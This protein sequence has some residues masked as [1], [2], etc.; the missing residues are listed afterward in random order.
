MSLLSL[1]PVVSDIIG[2]IITNK[3]EK[4]AALAQLALLESTGELQ[5][6]LAQI[7]L[8]KEEAKS[9]NWFVAGW[10]PCVGW[11]G[12][13]GLAYAAVLEPL[14]RFVAVVMFKYQGTFPILD[15]TL[16]MQILFGLLGLGAYRTYEHVKGVSKK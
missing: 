12:A 9:T 4:E 2:K 3:A 11:I 14:V 7:E 15:T 16:T 13:L 1:V 8:N 10:R 5:K 6:M